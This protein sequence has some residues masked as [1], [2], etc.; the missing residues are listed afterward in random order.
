MFVSMD[1]VAY[2]GPGKVIPHWPAGVTVGLDG[3]PTIT[4]KKDCW[5]GIVRLEKKKKKKV[6]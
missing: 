5:G 4:E 1:S 3:N 6:N 2:Y